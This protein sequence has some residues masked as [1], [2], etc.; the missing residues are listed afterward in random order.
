M[1]SVRLANEVWEKIRDHTVAPSED[2]LY[3]MINKTPYRAFIKFNAFRRVVARLREYKKAYAALKKS[4][5]NLHL[6]E[7]VGR[8]SRRPVESGPVD[9][10]VSRQFDDG[11]EE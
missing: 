9:I 11:E 10:T 2:R 1:H 6:I 7:T 4:P 5:N 8:L 3:D